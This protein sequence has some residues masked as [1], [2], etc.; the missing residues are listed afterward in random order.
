MSKYSRT[1]QIKLI[2]DYIGR[3]D[4]LNSIDVVISIDIGAKSIF[5]KAFGYSNFEHKLKNTTDTK[6][7]IGSNTKLFTAVAVLQLVERNEITLK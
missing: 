5:R 6:F 2:E 7:L 3:L 1:Y 4:S